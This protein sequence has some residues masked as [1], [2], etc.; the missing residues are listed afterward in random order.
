[1]TFECRAGH[2]YKQDFSKKKQ[3]RGVSLSWWK[4]MLTFWGRANG[5]VQ[6]PRW[7]CKKCKAADIR[8][9]RFDRQGLR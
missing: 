4:R 2:Q 8:A 3:T 1:M 6:C 5:G 7:D 9:R